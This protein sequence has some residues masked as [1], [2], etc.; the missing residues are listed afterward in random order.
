M[1][2]AHPNIANP[3]RADHDRDNSCE[4]EQEV[5]DVYNNDDVSQHTAHCGS[6]F[7]FCG[8]IHCEPV[9]RALSIV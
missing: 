3:F 8:W 1:Q 6:G 5:Q 2:K 4:N 7:P 9:S